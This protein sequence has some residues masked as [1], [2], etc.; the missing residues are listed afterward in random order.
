MVP[1]KREFEREAAG[2]ARPKPIHQREEKEFAR[3]AAV[4]PVPIVDFVDRVIPRQ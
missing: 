2:V 4:M 3:E 1:R